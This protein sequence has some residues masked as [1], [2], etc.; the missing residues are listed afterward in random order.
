MALSLMKRLRLARAASI[1]IQR[2][3]DKKLGILVTCLQL[4]KMIHGHYEFDKWG[5]ISGRKRHQHVAGREH[6]PLY[7]ELYICM[8]NVCKQQKNALRIFQQQRVRQLLLLL[9][10]T[11]SFMPQ[12]CWRFPMQIW[13]CTLTQR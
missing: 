9:L 1:L 10:Y 4:I 13:L 3:K 12:N 7:K 11:F 8:K 2:D 6:P 5:S